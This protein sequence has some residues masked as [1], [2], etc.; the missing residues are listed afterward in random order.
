MHLFLAL[1]VVS[2]LMLSSSTLP[3]A[4]SIFWSLSKEMSF[5]D[6]LTQMLFFTHTS[7]TAESTVLI[8][9]MLDCS[10]TTCDTLR[11][12]TVSMHVV[13]AK[14]GLAALAQS[15]CTMFPAT[16]LL[17]RLPFRGHS[18][19]P[20]IHYEHRGIARLACID[21]P[22]NIWF[23]FATTLLCPGCSSQHPTDSSS[24]PSSGSPPWPLRLSI[25]TE[26]ISW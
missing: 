9:V 1:L 8:A 5:H 20:H 13:I 22:T 21:I 2:D 23:W 7:F 14:T 3:K 19:I 24:G 17:L 11:C 12:T 6:C 16:F 10:I 4:L 15:F 26:Q 18:V 25:S